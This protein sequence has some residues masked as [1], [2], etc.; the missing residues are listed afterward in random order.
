M[1]KHMFLENSY[2]FQRL[3]ERHGPG[4]VVQCSVKIFDIFAGCQVPTNSILTP[5]PQRRRR[6]GQCGQRQAGVGIIQQPVQR[7]AT[8]VHAFGHGGFV[9]LLGFYQP[10]TCRHAQKTGQT[11]VGGGVLTDVNR[12]PSAR[13]CALAAAE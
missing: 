9:E 13:A 1:H 5:A 11:G 2:I 7:R 4:R 3:T 8:G 10:E 12:K 6:A